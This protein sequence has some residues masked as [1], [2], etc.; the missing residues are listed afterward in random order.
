M[1]LVVA[2]NISKSFGKSKAISNLSLEINKGKITGLVGPDGAGKTTLIRLMTGLLDLD[3][4]EL[5]VLELK[6]PNEASKVQEQIGY[7]PQKFGLYEDL[8][9]LENLKLYA[10]LQSIEKSKQ[11]SRIEELLEFINLKD[12]KSFLAKDLSG[13]MKQKL[14][15]AC[16]LIKKP[17]LLLLDE[18]GVGVDPISRKELWAIVDKLISDGVGVVWSTAY[19]DE[20]AICDEVILLNEGEILFSGEPKNLSNTME[21]KIFKVVGKIKDKRKTLRLA[22]QNTHIKDGVIL[23]DS[24]KLICDKKENLPKLE[25]LEANEC[26]YEPMK[27]NFEDGFMN[28]LKGEFN[29][30]SK[31]AKQMGELEK[32]DSKYLIEAENLTKSFGSFKATDSVNFQI[33]AGEIFG[34]LGPNGAGKS[35]TFKM[36]CGLLKPT[37]GTAQVLGMSLEKSSYKARKK[38]GYM[39]QKFSLYGDISVYENLKFFAGV[40]GLKGKKRSDKINNMIEIFELEKYKRTASKD[41]PL[42]YKQRLSLACAVMHDP[43]VLFLDEPTSG[44]DPQTRREFWNHIYAMVQKGMTIMVTTHFMDEAEYCDR[45]ALIYKGKAIALDTPHNLISQIGEDATMEEAFIELIKREDND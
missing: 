44:I 15:L 23:G 26:K 25:D 22:L 28:I 42:G 12:F 34:F 43:V 39:S 4:G 27:P 40:Y 35:T 11:Q 29:G 3:E 31:L 2:K 38:I 16:A 14:G 1:A 18:P 32:S 6:L 41:L 36:L 45:I 9:V 21:G 8:S 19:L 20:A 17:K 33:E 30:E 5:E 7:M 24:I 13:G 37:S 10:N